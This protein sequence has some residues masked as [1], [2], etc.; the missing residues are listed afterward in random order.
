MKTYSYLITTAL[1]M[2]LVCCAT[3]SNIQSGS[4]Q[5]SDIATLTDYKGVSG[6]SF[7]LAAF[8]KFPDG[9]S[10]SDFAEQVSTFQNSPET[11]LANKF[12]EEVSNKNKWQDIDRLARNFVNEVRGKQYAWYYHQAVA[13]GILGQYLTVQPPT[14]EVQKAIEYYLDLLLYYKTYNEVITFSK[15][16]P[17][18]N[19]YWSNERLLETTMVCYKSFNGQLSP[20]QYVSRV[21]ARKAEKIAQ[22]SPE[23]YATA[24]A[25]A[26]LTN[27]VREK[28]MYE[29]IISVG[30]RI[31]VQAQEVD[32]D[33]NDL[34][35]S[36]SDSRLVI[37]MLS[38]YLTKTPNTQK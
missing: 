9:M 29:R 32:R 4:S 15:A 11:A 2:L 12:L 33:L 27:E 35:K 10:S 36:V 37:A 17:M 24:E 16:L 25:I 30:K 7:S 31:Q 22:A 28:I 13:A 19:G 38:D 18:L 34:Q 1:S 20:N 6:K 21:I 8:M 5:N 26:A 14:I 23:K 3:Q